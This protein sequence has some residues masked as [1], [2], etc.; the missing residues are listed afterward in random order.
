MSPPK[1]AGPTPS[2]LWG[3]GP[4]APMGGAAG[5]QPN[6]PPL[7]EGACQARSSNT[8][9]SSGKPC[10]KRIGTTATVGTPVNSSNCS[11]A[12]ASSAASPL[13]LFS[14]KPAMRARS[15]SGSSAQVP[16][17]CAKAPPRS[18]SV[19]SRQRAL[20]CRATRRFTTSLAIRLISAGEPAP[21]ITTT[22]F[23]AISASSA[24]AMCGHTRSLR[25]RQGR[26]VSSRFTCPISTTWLRV[27][28]SGLSSSGFMRTSG[29][30]RAAR[31]WKYWAEPISPRGAPAPS[32]RAAGPHPNP[33][34]TGEGAPSPI[35]S[36]AG[37]RGS[38]SMSPPKRAGPTP[39]PLWGEGWGEGPAAPVGGA[40]SPHPPPAD[41]GAT[42]PATTRALLLMF[43]ALNGATFRPWLA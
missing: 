19:T 17:R 6:P 28:A 38:K 33:P 11:G 2:P 12:G 42:P 7:G 9:S 10:P 34:P 18:M 22:S 25:P 43:C 27:S 5:P 21:S 32:A 14:T 41:E 39:S 4:A 35:L 16:Y 15:S 1:R 37:G 13:N 29:S 31:A 8:P 40:A 3:E 30:A 36:P 23:S 20:A 26:S 24:A